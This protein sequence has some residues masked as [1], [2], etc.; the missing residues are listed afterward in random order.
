MLMIFTVSGCKQTSNKRAVTNNDTL[1]ES[2]KNDK[3][4]ISDI[5]GSLNNVSYV[6]ENGVIT[7]TIYHDSLIDKA[8]IYNTQII[9]NKLYLSFSK[10]S[11]E[12]NIKYDM[13]FYYKGHFINSCDLEKLPAKEGVLFDYNKLISQDSAI[14]IG[15]SC[16]HDDNLNFER[17]MIMPDS[18]ST[19]YIYAKRQDCSD[20]KTHIV[21]KKVATHFEKL[22]EIE[23]TDN[24]LDFKILNDSILRCDYNQ[25]FEDGVDKYEFKYN[26]IKRTVI[27]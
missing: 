9:D 14:L 7:D 20:W 17:F 11:I 13:S 22:F 15:E 16:S 10:Y 24:T 23:S 21:I 18:D 8:V 1:I 4:S 3:K 5:D 26:L 6:A 27:E 19:I 12:K 25:M 2:Q